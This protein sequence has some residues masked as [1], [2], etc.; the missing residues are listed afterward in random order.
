MECRE[1]EKK[2]PLYLKNSL[3][4]ETMEA[5][6]DHMDQCDACKEE[7]SIQFLVQEGMRHLENGDSFDLD[8]EFRNRLEISRRKH[9]RQGFFIGLGQ[10]VLTFVFFVLGCAVII[11]FG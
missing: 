11:L 3:D 1:F 7:L 9:V 5:F 8:K 6:Q 2:I 4:F 10:W